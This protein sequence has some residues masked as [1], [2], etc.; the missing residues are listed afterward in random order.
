M[1]FKTTQLIEEAYRNDEFQIF[2]IYGPFGYGKSSFGIQILNELF[3]LWKHNADGSITFLKDNWQDI[4]LSKILFH[5]RDFVYRCYNKGADSDSDSR[6]KTIVWDDAGYWLHA[7]DFNHPM[8]KAV[9]KYLNVARTDFASIIFT[10]PLP[11]WITTKIRNLP[12]AITLK[13]IKVSGNS[14]QKNLRRANAFRYWVAPD[15]RKSGV[16]K[17]YEDDFSVKLP[18]PVFEAYKP[19]RKKYTT[20][21]SRNMLTELKEIDAAYSKER[22]V[23]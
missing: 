13:V 19:L 4:L 20:E 11:T 1:P 7:L 22:A 6:E 2:I 5:P 10:A 3:G 8:V 21:A 15:M 12:Q 18:D 17:I 23:I 14:F 16:R 9:A